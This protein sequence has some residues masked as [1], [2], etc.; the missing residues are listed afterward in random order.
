MNEPRKPSLIR[1]WLF[2]SVWASGAGRRALRAARR[3]GFSPPRRARSSRSSAPLAL[4]GRPASARWKGA[5]WARSSSSSI[6][7]D[8]PDAAPAR[9]ARGARLVAPSA[10][11]RA[12]CAS[13]GCTPPRSRSRP[14]PATGRRANPPRWRCRCALV[15]EQ[16][17]V[18]R[19]R[20]GT[21]GDEKGGVVLREVS[22]KLAAGPGAPGSWGPREAVDA[23]RPGEGFGDAGCARAVHARRE[24]RARRQRETTRPIARPSR[25]AGPLAKFEARLAG[26]RRR[27]FRHGGGEPRAVFAPTPLRS[28]VREARKESISPRSSP[29]RT[30]G[31]RWRRISPPRARHSSPAPVK[32]VNADPG[33]LDKER[34][35]VASAA[36]QLRVA[37]DRVEAKKRR[38]VVRRRRR[39]DGRGA[40][41]RREARREA[42]GEGWRPPRVAFGAEGDEARRRH[43]CRRD[44]RRAVLQRGA[45]RPALRDPRRRAHRAGPPH[46]G[47]RPPC[48]R[49]GLRGSAGNAGAS[50]RARVRGRGAHRAP[51]SRGL[52]E[53]AGRG[54]ERRLHR[55]GQ[56]RQGGGR[57]GECSTSRRAASRDWPPKAAWRSPPKGA[58]VSRTEADV[59]LGATR[60]VAK[61]ALG[62]AGDT[63]DA[64]ARLSRTSAPI[65]RAFGLALGGRVDLEAKLSGRVHRA[66]GPCLAARRRTSRCPARFAWRRRRARSSWARAKTGAANGQ[67]ELRGSR[68]RREKARHGRARLGRRSREREA[69]TRSGS[70][71]TSPTSPSA[72]ALLDG[73]VVPGA[74]LPEWRGRLESLAND[75]SRRISRSR[76]RPRSSSPPI[77]SSWARRRFAGEPGEVRLAF[78]RW[79]PG[80]PGVARLVERRRDS[81][82]PRRS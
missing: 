72:R 34:L 52:R 22:L 81:H 73:G 64:E 46:G 59:S 30:R 14:S 31:S 50:R 28:L 77:A 32:I 42:R 5:S 40:V 51:R 7:M 24:G 20:V 26:A 27:A 15:V 61:G 11:R 78:T 19:L 82:H 47:A 36:A 68:A 23:H 4:G 74:R 25:R 71:R 21:I 66:L 29:R 39:R 76:R 12:R 67:V 58:R 70:R 62:S 6:E 53:G 48:A 69:R 45:R 18:D 3:S 10:P 41:V 44:G 60:L 57:R 2:G 37:K 56:S 54:A 80:G 55:E 43:R 1:R 79:T 63:L 16:A 49:R 33:P 9:R 65:G 35:P 13:S 75:G 17:G 38:P 8:T